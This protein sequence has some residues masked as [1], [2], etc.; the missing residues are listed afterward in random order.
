MSGISQNNT[1][2]ALVLMPF[3]EAYDDIYLI[4]LKEV[5]EK[6]GYHCTRVDE[7]FFPGQ[8]IEEIQRSIAES[9]VIVAEMTDKNANVYYEVGYAHGIGKHPILVTKD[10]K[11][12]P[13][14]LRGYKHIVYRG[15]IKTLRVEL[16]K[17]LDWLEQ[18]S[19]ASYEIIRDPTKLK[20][21]SK[22][23]L[24]HLYKADEDRPAAECAE[25]AKGVFAVLN[26]LR[27]LGYVKFYGPLL[28]NV[29]IHLT[30]TGKKAA[31]RLLKEVGNS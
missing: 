19:S 25:T 14:D 1:K 17:Y 26:D 29:P 23:V 13:F 5:L 7:K 28:S 27:F 21:E 10:D 16:D 2:T 20:D 31:K 15:E 30:E 8:I 6:R 18:A 9:D 22:A 11:K 24:M 12:L 3:D 4:G